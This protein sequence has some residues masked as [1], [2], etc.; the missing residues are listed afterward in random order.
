MKVLIALDNSP[1]SLRA[2]AYAAEVLPPL[3]ECGFLLLALSPDIP[4]G[5]GEL[6]PAGPVPELHGDEDHREE[7]EALQDSLDE[8]AKLLR[9]KGVPADRL[10]QRLRAVNISV[11][12]DI[13]DIAV[14]EGCDTVVMGRRG[15]SRVRELVQGSVS[16]E[17]VHKAVNLT[18]WVVA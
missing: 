10:S 9:D 11:A 18:V 17:V 7:L 16:S 1:H 2:A 3:P 15:L 5:S 13:V 14:A 6:D 12:Q 4:E 8:A